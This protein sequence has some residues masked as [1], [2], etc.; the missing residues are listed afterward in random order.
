MCHNRYPQPTI[1]ALYRAVFV[2]YYYG[3]NKIS[4]FVLKGTNIDIMYV[5][6]K[7]AYVF[8]HEG[9]SYGTSVMLQSRG[10]TDIVAAT[11]L[12]LTSALETKEA[13]D[14]GENKNESIS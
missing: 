3:M 6:G 7:L 5:K 10:I 1:T 4:S 13:L 14:R 9:K 2:Y 8:Q 12:L 11:F